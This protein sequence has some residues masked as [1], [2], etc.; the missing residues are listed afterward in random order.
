VILIGTG[1]AKD[2]DGISWR[3]FDARYRIYGGYVLPGSQ[4][5]GAGG[6]GLLVSQ[7]HTARDGLT[8][9]C[10]SGQPFAI[11]LEHHLSTLNSESPSS[12]VP[13]T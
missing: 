5:D 12:G 7:W 8:G 1:D 2:D 11:P 10:N 13:S 9:Q 4:L 6:V 3:H